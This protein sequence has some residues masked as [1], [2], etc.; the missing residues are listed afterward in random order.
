MKYIIMCGSYNGIQ[1]E[2]PRQT[3][4]INNEPIIARTIRLLKEAGVDDIAIT[5]DKEVFANFNV[6]LIKYDSNGIWV[7]A[8]YPTQ[9]PTCYL[10]GDVVYSPKA[11]ETIVKTE[12]K[13]VMFF[14]SRPPFNSNYCK[15]HAEPFAFKVQNTKH[16]FECVGKLKQ[17]YR[18][19]KV[20]RAISWELWQVIK[21][22]TLDQIN[23][24][25]YVPINDYTCDVDKPEDVKK[26]E[27][28]IN[29]PKSTKYLIHSYQKRLWYVKQYLIPSMLER[30]IKEENIA[31]YNDDK[32]EGNLKACMNAFMMVEDNDESTW[33]L[34]DDVCISKNFKEKTEM[35]NRGLVCG[36]SSLKYDGPGKI[37]IVKPKEMWFSFPAI[38]IPNKYA[39]ECSKWVNE[40]LIGNVIYRQYWQSGRNDDWAFRKYIE[41]FHKKDNVLN[42]TP[43]IVDHIDYLIGGGSG[44]QRQEP[45][46]AQ[47]FRDL[48]VVEE[49]EWQIKNQKNG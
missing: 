46:R 16:F 17:L 49:L 43:N 18:E 33:H 29:N 21:N 24:N 23:Y 19:G 4:E 28:C 27:D 9:E 2:Q 26:I 6:P 8:F 1:F 38:C 25:N 45:V 22:T 20:R 12:I 32:H 37:G 47:Y 36:F 3:L 34:Q 10:F 31:L 15:N 35:Y 40:E 39:R 14:A 48:D 7:N 13:D 42:L 11:I 44:G 41:A 5:S 30:G